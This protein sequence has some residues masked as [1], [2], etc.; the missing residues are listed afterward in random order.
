MSAPTLERPA[1]YPGSPPPVRTPPPAP[2]QPLNV[3]V[4]IPV[5][6]AI[7]T[8]FTALCLGNLFDGLEWW[9]LP[10]AGGIALAAVVGVAA[11][12]LSVPALLMPLVYLVAGWLYVIPVATS[13][14]EFSSRISLAPSGATFTGLRELA[15]AAGHDIRTLT[16]PVPERPGFLFLTV[17]GVFLVAAAVD[18]IAAGLR[19]PP[20][21]GL[22]LL[23]L[24][25]V[26]AAVVERGVGLLAFTAACVSY[27]WLLLAAGRQELLSWARLRT[28]SEGRLVSEW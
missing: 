19:R 9:L 25:A 10:A 28:D 1:R 17:A 23:A 21:A 26:P 4:P 20:A 15:D 14:S 24:L 7:C 18:G 3:T 27:I 11:R 22:P 8:F 12:R 6:A 16:V 5:I 13:G 2:Q